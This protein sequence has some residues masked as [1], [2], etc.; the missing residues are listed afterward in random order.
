MCFCDW[1]YARQNGKAAL[2][3]TDD[4]ATAGMQSV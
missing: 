2:S 3:K 4:G 1:K